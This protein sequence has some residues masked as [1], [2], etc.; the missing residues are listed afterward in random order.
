MP[1][2]VSANE[3][4]LS[5]V[6]EAAD[7]AK[8][9]LCLRNAAG[10]QLGSHS[11]DLSALSP[12]AQL[13]LFDLHRYLQHYVAPEPAAQ[14]QA[15]AQTGVWIAEKLLG[16]QIFAALWQQG[17]I[18]QRSL[19]ITLPDFDQH[20][21]HNQH[22]C[23]A[24]ARVPWEIARPSLD[25]PTLQEKNLLLH[26]VHENQASIVQSATLLDGEALRVVCVFADAKGTQP[27]AARKERL[28]LQ[29]L[30]ARHIATQRA[31]EV[32]VLSH[33]VSRVRLRAQI[34]QNSGYH[35]VHWSG[36]GSC[37][38]LELAQTDGQ[39]DRLTG[40]ELVALLQE[41][42]G[43]LPNLFFLSACNSG[44]IDDGQHGAP[45]KPEVDSHPINTLDELLQTAQAVQRD[46]GPVSKA[47]DLAQ[48]PGYTG[49]AHALLQAGVPA[50][51]AMRH[52]VG[53]DYARE[54]A[55]HF[56][57]A[58]LAHAQPKSMAAALHL[59]RLALQKQ[60]AKSHPP[61]SPSDHATAVLYCV[62]RHGAD[63]HCAAPAASQHDH[64]APRKGR[65]LPEITEL[66]AQQHRNFV[67]RTWE[68][69]ALTENF[70]GS[71]DRSQNTAN[72]TSQ[73]VAQIIGLGGMGKTA[74]CAEVLDLWQQHFD[75]LLLY[76]AKP[77][78]LG[79]DA[80]LRD[81]HSRLKGEQGR[82][83]QYVQRYPADAIYREADAEF[84]GEERLQRMRKNLLRAM[85]D[86]AILLVLD[87]FE[88]NLQ[89]QPQQP[90]AGVDA[91]GAPH[92]ACQDRAW[93][94]LL[95]ML[96]QGLGESGSRL[97]ITCRRPLVALAEV[98]AS[99]EKPVHLLALGP[100]PAGEAALYL[101][102]H[103]VL[104]GMLFGG[105]SSDAALAQRLLRASRFHPLLMDRL[106]KLAAQPALRQQLQQAI[107]TLEARSGFAELPALCSSKPG[108]AL[109]QAYLQDALEVSLDQLLTYSSAE[110][111]QLLWVI[112]VANEP[113]TLDLLS[114]V[115]HGEESE[116]MQQMRQIKQWLELLPQQQQEVPEEEKAFLNNL[117]Q[118][119]LSELQALPPA[120]GSKQD[121]APL[122]H[123]LVR[124][125]LVNEALEGFEDSN[126]EI[127]CHELVRERIRVWMQEQKSE[128]ADWPENLIRLAYAD[129]LAAYFK[130]MQHKNMA[131]A[132]QAGSRAIVYCVQAG[133]YAKL[134]DF[135]SDIV[136]STY[137]PRLLQS[138]LPHLRSAAE[139][140]PEGE[141]RW[142]C[143]GYLADA[144][145]RGGQPEASLPFY[146]QA[147][148]Q[149]RA[150]AEAGAAGASQAWR[151]LGAICANAANVFRA[152]GQLEAARQHQHQSAAA[153]KQ[154]GWSAL[155][156]WGNEL[157]QLRIDIMQGKAAQVLP[158]VGAKLAQV[159]GW[160]HSL[161]T[162]Q[163]VA[164]AAEQES[165][166]RAY[167]S[168]LDI[169]RE[170]DFAMQNWPAALVRVDTTL[171]VQRTLQRPRED[172]AASRMN[173]AIVLG[174]LKRFAEAISEM[175]ACLPLFEH[176]LA[177][178]AKV[179]G[180]LA[181]LFAM[182]NDIVQALA[183]LRR[184]LA[185]FEDL[186]APAERAASHNNLATY[187]FR[188]ASPPAL[189][190][191][192]WHQL[193]GLVYL[194][195]SGLHQ[196]LQMSL[197]NY[198]NVFRLARRATSTN[199]E[200]NIPRLAELLARP[201]FAPLSRW[202]QQRAI[203]PETMQAEI[204]ELLAQVRQ[205]V[206]AEGDAA[207]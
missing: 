63:Q 14:A 159:A 50:V 95:V 207:A 145:S 134:G 21:Q 166:A 127:S 205:N 77:N 120:V 146:L 65:R 25:Q 49:T 73:P 186:P 90:L 136:T 13:A 178:K 98:S 190:E 7:S 94:A 81:I 110:A 153:Q 69:S 130:S 11:V 131:A 155:Y 4:A 85:Q 170:A 53:D 30:F 206:L 172:I 108:N 71:L 86:E 115:W 9:Q 70:I 202:L 154:G 126:P 36:R 157:A 60:L 76:Q 104:C 83:C 47:L 26:V 39:P 180:S 169:A 109:E 64:S 22:Y 193:A 58:L 181:S 177:A 194:L 38:A 162:G 28:A 203:V 201:E 143:L 199:A 182:Q 31:V 114:V 183:Q 15:M 106:V 19:R 57:D 174:A 62:A 158:Q 195:A 23:A 46:V 92:W 128:Q 74:L 87:N 118:E 29:A 167:L 117:P 97:L 161:R 33:G 164:E 140:A 75:Y 52:A 197:R 141:P 61:F 45:G 175:E 27:L 119:E 51:V 34:M 44:E 2:P 18:A 1:A 82:Y 116:Q 198:A 12:T 163:P 122:L 99:A 5:I 89:P 32:H 135:A 35:I 8:A 160:W 192:R 111:R 59:A 123:Q 102:Q 204:D 129:Q 200:P 42:G 16:E 171:E 3:F 124:L 103:P 142:R 43:I 156:I 93:D 105:N 121:I 188:S 150:V 79:F 179:L 196:Y 137:D 168:A 96:A 149:A 54:L 187:L 101:R 72:R 165:L 10:E 147:A 37:D 185:L 78:A 56:Y 17:S 48:R 191:A 91:S 139:A 133:A 84:T 67:G 88:N 112:S 151:D 40:A 132:L 184:A 55:L 41:A 125:G 152:I 6:T 138:L 100:L 66:D 144:L 189:E 80:T 68:I 20:N 24:L 148:A 113:V 176:N 107:S 173:R